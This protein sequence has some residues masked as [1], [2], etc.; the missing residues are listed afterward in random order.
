MERSLLKEK[1][2][3][4]M[5]HM[6][7]SREEQQQHQQRRLDTSAAAIVTATASPP[8]TTTLPTTQVNHS[9]SNKIQMQ[10][11]PPAQVSVFQLIAKPILAGALTGGIESLIM[12]PTEYVKTH[13]QLQD[14]KNPRYHGMLDC[15]KKT[16][17]EHGFLG[18]YRGVTP[19]VIGSIPKQASRWGSYEM[20]C[21]G[22]IELKRRL[23]GIPSSQKLSKKDLTMAEISVCGFIAGSVEALVAV[24]PTETVKTVLIHD[25]K[26]ARPRFTNRSLFYVVGTLVREEGFSGIYRGVSNT[27]TKQGLNQSTRFPSQLAAMNVFCSNQREHRRKSPFWNGAAGFCAGVFSVAITQPF[28]VVKTKMQGIDRSQY[29]SSWDCW[30][31]TAKTNGLGHFY[32]GSAARTIRVGGNVA[33]TFTLF[34]LIKELL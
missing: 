5:T 7:T 33:L 19:L 23:F 18:L 8:M 27:V 1:E 14:K 10:Q 30:R 9:N 17:K 4:N 15:Y 32:A 13:L 11:S 22:M 24:V 26:S 6:M 2:G 31:Q 3:E 21:S 12:Y 28:D 34:P 25:E 16:V 29:A 20:S